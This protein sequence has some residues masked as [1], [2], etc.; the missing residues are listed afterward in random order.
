MTGE[1]LYQQVRRIIENLIATRSDVR[2]PL[3]SSRYLAASLG[4]SRNTVNA[5]YEE[6]I[7]LGLVESRPRSGLYPSEIAARPSPP[8]DRVPTVGWAAR[9]RRPASRIDAPRVHPDW[10]RYPYPFLP[11]QPELGAFP[12]R[13]WTRALTDALYGPHLAFSVRDSSDRDDPLLVEMIRT[14]ILASR[15]VLTAAD[16]ILVTHG[17]QEALSLVA[18]VLFGPGVTVAV[19]D[20][21]YRDAAHIV[22]E[23]GADLL[24]VPVDGAGARVPEDARF[25][26]LHLTPSHQHPTSVTLGYPRRREILRRARSEDFVVI[27]D[28]YDSEVRFRGRPTPSL[29]S[30]DTDGRVVY[31]GTF[32]KF[33]APGIRMGFVVAPPDLIALLRRRRRYANRHPNGHTQRALA[34]FIQS[35]DYHR[36]LRGHRNHLR[37]KWLAL[38]GALAESL[39]WPLEPPP[40][41]GMSI[42]VTGPAD[43]DGTA[44]ASAALDR[45]VLIDPG[46]AFHLTPDAGR[47]SIRVGFN[48]IPLAAIA[49]GVAVLA[50]VIRAVESS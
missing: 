42:W 5:A 22:T 34:L 33:V 8:P 23:S 37:R 41:G 21:G 36:A 32:S 20:P 44:V 3:P 9:A 14:E 47:A 24:P 46:S 11:G 26:Y 18:D 17:A 2:R 39:P 48:A 6:L 28:D 49:P 12:A 50:D 4:V 10:T 1:P 40:A 15:G 27:E 38:S 7:A 25:D 16:T 35:G 43:F 45:G 29:K 31:V 13:G 19:E 30:L